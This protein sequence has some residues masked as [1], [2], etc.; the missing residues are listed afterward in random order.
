MY[1]L[2]DINEEMKLAAV[3]AIASLVSDDELSEDFIIPRALDER[4]A[5]VVA[6]AV[7]K[8]AIE[9]GVSELEK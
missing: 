5:K 2:T 4:V 6:T 9:T 7:G 1:E 8:A 3:E